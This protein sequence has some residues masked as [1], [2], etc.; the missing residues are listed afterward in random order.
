MTGGLGRQIILQR[1]FVQI[2]NTAPEVDFPRSKADT[3]L[4]LAVNPRTARHAQAFRHAGTIGR[5]AGRDGRQAVGTLD[6]IGGA[7]FLNAQEGAPEITA[8]GQRLANQA[9][10]FG[11]SEMALP[12]KPTGLDT[13]LHPDTRIA[14]RHRQG[15]CD[16]ISLQPGT[17]RHEAGEHQER[18]SPQESEARIHGSSFHR[19][20][21]GFPQC[22]IP[23]GRYIM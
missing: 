4:I 16:E 15:G 2:G 6:A 12:A 22:Y 7:G 21:C 10:Q 14:C 17:A 18:Q 5:H 1:R 8:V 23:T 19:S 11:I 3:G 13:G 9:A 20:G